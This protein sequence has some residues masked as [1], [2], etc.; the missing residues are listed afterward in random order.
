MVNYYFEKNQ[1]FKVEVY[2]DNDGGKGKMIG[3]FEEGMNSLLTNKK[4]CLTGR[5]DVPDGLKGK[6]DS[7]VTVYAE[8][9]GESNVEIKM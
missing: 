3:S 9:V 2:D 4:S 1:K 5:L 7:K 8:P 6:N